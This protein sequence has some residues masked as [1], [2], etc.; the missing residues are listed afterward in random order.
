MYHI[1]SVFAVE[2]LFHTLVLRLKYMN[3]QT[4]VIDGSSTHLNN[5]LEYETLSLLVTNIT[6]NG[7]D[8][9]S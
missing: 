2:Q 6:I 7:E 4:D 5:M 3:F 9:T 1:T 8:G